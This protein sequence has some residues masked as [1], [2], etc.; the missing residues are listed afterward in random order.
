MF[1]NVGYIM[2]AESAKTSRTRVASNKRPRLRFGKLHG[3]PSSALGADNVASATCVPVIGA[4]SI[5]RM[6]GMN[7]RDKLGLRFNFVE[8]AKGEPD[9]QGLLEL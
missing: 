2:H 4:P 3:S 1:L 7:S 8:A 9:N 6:R 5:P